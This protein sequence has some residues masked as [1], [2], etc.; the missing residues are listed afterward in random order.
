M[1][2]SEAALLLLRNDAALFRP[3]I[4][5]PDFF[6]P[7]ETI[8]RQRERADELHLGFFGSDCHK[9]PGV[10][11]EPLAEGDRDEDDELKRNDGAE[12]FFLASK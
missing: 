2:C 8:W 5:L 7:P 1:R 3:I 12:F 4:D 10:P 6:L 9:L 11:L